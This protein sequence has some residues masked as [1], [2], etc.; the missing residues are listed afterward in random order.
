MKFTIKMRNLYNKK[1]VIVWVVILTM[2]M[3]LLFSGPS[4]AKGIQKTNIEVSADIAEPI[5][6]VEGDLPL[7]I[8]TSN[9]NKSY[10]FKVKNYDE[11]EKL[12]QVNIEY[13]LEVSRQT[14]NDVLIKVYKEGE[15]LKLLKNRTEKFIF[16]S[17]KKQEDNYR[18][19]ILFNNSSSIE[20]MEEKIEV[21]VHA[22]QK[23]DI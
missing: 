6:E 23:E 12:T 7:Y 15:E 10:E 5:L 17:T 8:T 9:Q 18:I 21:K 13:Y 20:E 22:E 16:E 14:N 2:V 3:L 19:E 11:E 1:R 4:I